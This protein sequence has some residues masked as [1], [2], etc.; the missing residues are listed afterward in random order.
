MEVHGSA[1]GP[2]FGS[3]GPLLDVAVKM[4]RFEDDASWSERL[5]AGKVTPSDVNQL[6]R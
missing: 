4:R 2:V 6:A 3:D 1:D 5:A